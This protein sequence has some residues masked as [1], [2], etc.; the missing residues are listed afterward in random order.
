MVH[1]ALKIGDHC[2]RETFLCVIMADKSSANACGK[3]RKAS[4]DGASGRKR[5]AI[6]METKMAIIKKLDSGEKM[7]NAA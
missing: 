7:T 2:F 1:E 3:K 5:R 6:S 4:D